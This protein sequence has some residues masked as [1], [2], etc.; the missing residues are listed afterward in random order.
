MSLDD[1]LDDDPHEEPAACAPSAGP[2]YVPQCGA[3]PPGRRGLG[4][5]AG[6]RAVRRLVRVTTITPR[7][8]DSVNAAQNSQP[9]QSTHAR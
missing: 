9:N 7:E 5:R 2:T 8:T 1:E 4:R 6:A 3:L